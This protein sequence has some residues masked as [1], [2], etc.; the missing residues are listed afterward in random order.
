MDF[1]LQT[2]VGSKVIYE[3]S[4]KGEFF[5]MKKSRAWIGTAL[6]ASRLIA[7][8]ATDQTDDEQQD[9]CT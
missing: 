9:Y 6:F 2:Y 3:T 5:R 7:L 8:A 1:S 4:G